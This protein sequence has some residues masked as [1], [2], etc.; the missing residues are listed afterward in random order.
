MRLLYITVCICVFSCDG[1]SQTDSLLRVLAESQ[2]DTAKVRLLRTLGWKYLLRDADSSLMFYQQSLD[3][4]RKVGDLKG[5]V[6]GVLNVSSTYNRRGETN[7]GYSFLHE[8][9]RIAKTHADYNLMAICYGRMATYYS[10]NTHRPDSALVYFALAEEYHIKAGDTY[11]TWETYLGRGEL[12]HMLGMA[13]KSEE[14]LLRAYE[15][16]SEKKIRMD[17]GIVLH[18]LVRNYFDLRQ[19]EKYSNFSDAYVKFLDEGQGQM[20][21]NNSA[22][23]ALYFFEDDANPEKSIP[24]VENIVRV[25]ESMQHFLLAIDALK[26]LSSLQDKA[27]RHDAAVISLERA[28]QIAAKY[29]YLVELE[30]CFLRLYVILEQNRNPAAAFEYFKKYK[31]IQDSVEILDNRKM[32]N[33]LEIKYATQQKD[34]AL[35]LQRLEIDKQELTQRNLLLLICLLALIAIATLGFLYFKGMANRTL[36]GKNAIIANSLTEKELLLREIHHRV[37]NNLQVISS[38]LNLQA[39]YIVDQKAVEAIKDGRNRV[40]SMSLI[41][42][43]LYLNENLATIDVAV[44]LEKLSD[45]LFQSYNIDHER[46]KLDVQVDQTELDVDTL[47]PLGLILNELISNSL[48]HAF[49]GERYG[50]I[51]VRFQNSGEHFFLEV[52]DNGIGMSGRSIKDLSTTFGIEMIQAFAQK[53]KAS[54]E[55]ESQEG[56]TVSLRIPKRAA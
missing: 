11:L 54:V 51:S 7:K 41:H 55:F 56:V 50:E 20:N 47:I 13:D 40:N 15:L 34:K 23:R 32:F 14:D 6:L 26:F 37:K 36:K 22:H 35:A 30:I 4:A 10:R 45:S 12:Y 52:K 18:R 53:L 28:V 5:E 1:L 19:W 3:L 31:A 8:A 42:Q 39:K 29:N 17:Q 24:V 38:L 49:P 48:K 9:L 33:E 46:I 21:I 43:N 27:G 25:H 2:E 16:T 44:Y